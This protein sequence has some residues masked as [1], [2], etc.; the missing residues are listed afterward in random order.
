MT[1]LIWGD[2]SER[3][4]ET[5][6]DRGVLYVDA[7]NGVAWNGLVSVSEKASGGDPKPAYLDGQKFRNLA[8]REEFEATIEAFS[9]P[10]DFDVCDGNVSIQNGLIATQQKRRAFSFAYRTKVGNAVDGQDHAYKIHLVYN[11]LAAPADR[12]NS[13]LNDSAEAATRSWE[14]TTL[15]PSLT[16]LKPTAHYI[17]DSRYT[18]RFLLST[19]EDI[20]YGSDAAAPRLPLPSE[21]TALFQSEGPLTRTN[22]VGNS[23]FRSVV[24]DVEVRRNLVSNP[25]FRFSSSTGEMRRNRVWNAGARVNFNYWNATLQTTGTAALSQV[26]NGG[27]AGVVESFV[28][29]T[30]TAVTTGLIP[31]TGIIFGAPSVASMTGIPGEKSSI[32]VY[33]RCSVSDRT[34]QLVITAHASDGSGQV[35]VFTGPIT[36][37]GNGWVRLTGTFVVPDGKPNLYA[38]IYSAGGRNW[39]VG[40]TMDA[41]AVLCEVCGYVGSWFDAMTVFTNGLTGNW[42]GTAHASDSQAI[43]NKPWNWTTKVGTVLWRDPSGGAWLLHPVVNDPVA[44]LYQSASDI[45][46]PKGTKTTHSLTLTSDPTNAPFDIKLD[47]LVYETGGLPVARTNGVMT[48]VQPGET[49]TLT[50]TTP[51]ATTDGAITRSVPYGGS[52]LGIP[53]GTKYKLSQSIVEAA[54]FPQGPFFDGSTAPNDG[55]IYSWVGAVDSSVSIATGKKVAG[56]YLGTGAILYRG[57]DGHSG[58]WLRKTLNEYVA[59][60]GLQALAAA[61]VGKYITFAMTIDPE[62]VGNIISIVFSWGTITGSTISVIPNADGRIVASAQIPNGGTNLVVY[63]PFPGGSGSSAV[64]R[65]VLRDVIVEISDNPTD[66]SY[67]DGSTIDENANYYSWT[68]APDQ[69][70]SELHTWN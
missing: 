57:E 12:T 32:S 33:T 55:L 63:M 43:G 62:S 30:A 67:F 7:A 16:G 8:T 61:N 10:K 5:G 53:A 38:R 39:Q 2:A 37:I 21:L 23:T 41:T 47:A 54:D 22:L 60:T 4:F 25:S 48:T 52:I 68:G 27:P 59:I 51:A 42:V 36:L 13:T 14:I 34:A 69:S 65:M 58:V 46:I 66:G 15:P 40:D 3:F 64:G 18:P 24:S 17:I 49:V 6:V 11:A 9:A 45:P 35:V 44:I 1:R 19:I 31:S 29:M 70:T 26:A 56:Y 28:R 50:T 20:L